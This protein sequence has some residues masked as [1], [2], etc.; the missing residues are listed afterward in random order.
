MVQDIDRLEAQVR[1]SAADK[2]IA[3]LERRVGEL[4][5]NPEK[6]DLN[7]LKQRMA[8]LDEKVVLATSAQT[9][10][11]IAIAP[12]RDTKSTSGKSQPNAS[13][14]RPRPRPSSLSLPE[15]EKRARLA[16]PAE[17]EAFNRGN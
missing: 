3:D 17:V 10:P 6:I 8:D 16:T 5:A 9:E 15:L 14:A 11:K 4:E 12:T 1:I 2:R 13:I 7:L